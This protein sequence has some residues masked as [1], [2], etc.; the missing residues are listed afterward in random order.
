VRIRRYPVI[1][2]VACA[3]ACLVS[4]R[5]VVAASAITVQP[6]Q[7]DHAL[8]WNVRVGVVHG[9]PGVSPH[10]CSQATSVASTLLWRDCIECL[11][12]KTA[13]AMSTTAVAI[14]IT[15]AVERPFRL[16]PTFTWPPHVSRG[17][18]FGGFEGLPDRIG[19]YQSHRRLGSREVSVLVF[20]GRVQPTGRQLNRANTEL[21][22]ARLNYC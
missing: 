15:V 14:Q 10:R 1:G 17:D 9:C 13:A 19:V 16:E 22:R 21:R 8:G 11:P 2:L 3:A 20:F 12:H 4:A 5:G 6:P 18:V 7:F